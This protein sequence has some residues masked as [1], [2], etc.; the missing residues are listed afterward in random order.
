MVLVMPMFGEGRGEEKPVKKMRK[1]PLKYENKDGVCEAKWTK[2]FERK[3][4]KELQR[5]LREK[6]R[7]VKQMDVNNRK[8]EHEG[9][10]LTS[11]F[12]V[13][14]L[15]GKLHKSKVILF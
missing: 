3:E 1:R 4:L 5:E 15:T 10:E 11:G 13:V 8:K 7:V 14:E 9:W 12:S 6:K 2:H